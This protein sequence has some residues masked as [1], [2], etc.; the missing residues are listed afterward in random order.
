VRL[1]NQE[2]KTEMEVSQGKTQTAEDIALTEWGLVGIVTIL[3]LLITSLPVIFAY[4]TTPPDRQF[5]GIM[6]DVPDHVQYFSWMREL[7]T[8]NLAANQLTP[9]PNAPIFFNL[10]WWTLGRLGALMGWGYPILFQLL[11][12]VATVLFLALVYRMCSWFLKER[13]ARQMAFLIIVF[14][15]G[16]GWVLVAGKYLLHLADLP[17]PLDVTIAEGN[18]F[19]GVLGYPHFIAAALYVF[20]F[21][22]ILRGE[23]K[24]RLRYAVWAGLIALFLGWQHAYDLVS[25]YGVI[26][27]YTLLR[28]LRDQ[29]IP[30]YLVKS[31][32]ILGLISV[33][34]ALY[35]VL[36]TRLD[37]VWKQVLAQFANAGVYTPGLLHLPILLGIPFLLALFTLVKDGVSSFRKT[38]NADLFIKSWF[39]I[40]FFL[41]YLPVDFQIHLLNGWQIPIGILAVQGVFRYILPWLARIFPR[42]PLPMLN[43]QKAATV[44]LIVAVIPTNIY[45]FGQ[46]FVELKRHDYPYY[47]YRDEVKAMTWLAN[48]PGSSS[49]VLSSLDTGEYIPAL[50]GQRAFLAHWAQTVNFFD[51]R[52]RVQEFFT[53]DADFYQKSATLKDFHVAYVFYGPAERALG[54]FNP[55]KMPGL[56][57]VYT[58][59]QVTIYQVEE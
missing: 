44:V 32:L 19:L 7:S 58:A 9:E 51:K 53:D 6:L 40:T 38:S 45:L 5:M 3:I 54:S 22:L 50:T 20:V 25:V 55:Q 27:A 52:D 29:K 57:P 18:T 56:R 33:W 12:V 26:F 48:R 37:P 46:R 4:Q 23:E 13:P 36:L 15:S 28:W 1:V 14:A 35:S 30:W 21:D 49:V 11:R 59:G 17:F 10:L 41:I 43:L 42:R 47:L 31:G 8:A 39:L 16:F 24:N 34:P 2:I